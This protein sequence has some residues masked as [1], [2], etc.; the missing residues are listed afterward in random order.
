MGAHY[1]RFQSWWLSQ[2]LVPENS[3]LSF[4][5][6]FDNLDKADLCLSVFP[7]WYLKTTWAASGIK[8]AEFAFLS[9][10]PTFLDGHRCTGRNR[11]TGI[12]MMVK[13]ISEKD[14][15]RPSLKPA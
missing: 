15:E 14:S 1:T 4:D 9:T 6:C 10:Q 2:V 5:S 3:M 13:P 12:A 7:W 8:G 11:E